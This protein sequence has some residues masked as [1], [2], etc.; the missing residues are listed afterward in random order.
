MEYRLYHYELIPFL[1]DELLLSTLDTLYDIMSIKPK[2]DLINYVYDYELIDLYIYIR[3]VTKEMNKRE[4]EIS[5]WFLNMFEAY[6]CSKMLT[7]LD[8]VEI[9]SDP[10]LEHHTDR[11]L[12]QCFFDIQERFDRNTKK[13]EKDLEL[14]EKLVMFITIKFTKYRLYDLIMFI[15]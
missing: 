1:P 8:K 6:F 14:M 11:Y 4:L 10:F 3:L 2:D 12:L 15:K 13:T 9:Y 7:N 5:P